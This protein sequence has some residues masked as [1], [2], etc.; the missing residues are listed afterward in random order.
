MFSPL[1]AAFVTTASFCKLA[2][3][4][5]VNIFL[6]SGWMQVQAARI[7]ALNALTEVAVSTCMD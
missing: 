5:R 4:N 7:K 6:H 2:A 3:I 1:N